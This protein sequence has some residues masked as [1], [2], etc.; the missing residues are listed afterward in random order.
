MMLKTILTGV[1]SSSVSKMW[2]YKSLEAMWTQT[3]VAVQ[4]SSTLDHSFT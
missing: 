4:H 1:F 2:K 3:D